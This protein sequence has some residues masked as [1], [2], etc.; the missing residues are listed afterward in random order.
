M[1]PHP[2]PQVREAIKNQYRQ[3]YPVGN[4]AKVI[5]KMTKISN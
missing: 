5:A 3:T 4:R 1:R 2:S